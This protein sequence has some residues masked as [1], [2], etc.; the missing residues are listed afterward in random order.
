M[1]ECSSLAGTNL[2]RPAILLPVRDFADYFAPRNAVSAG[3]ADRRAN[4]NRISLAEIRPA[5]AYFSSDA[6]RSASTPRASGSRMPSPSR[7]SCAIDGDG[8]SKWKQRQQLEKPESAWNLVLVFSLGSF[9]PS[10][11]AD[12]DVTTVIPLCDIHFF[13]YPVVRE[14][15]RE[16]EYPLITASRR[17]HRLP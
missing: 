11:S 3:W 1:L 7:F 5:A 6:A 14:H 15:I 8:D 9:Q 13:F 10:R 12:R 16:Q 17:L 4:G 2:H